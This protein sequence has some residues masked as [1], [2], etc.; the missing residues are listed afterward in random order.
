MLDAWVRFAPRFS[1]LL[2][3]ICQA[4][5]SGDEGRHTPADLQL[6]AGEARAGTPSRQCA[7]LDACGSGVPAADEG[8]DGDARRGRRAAARMPARI[9]ELIAIA[10]EKTWGREVGYCATAAGT[11]INPEIIARGAALSCPHY[12]GRYR[13]FERPEAL[14]AQPR[15]PYCVPRAGSTTW[16]PYIP[17]RPRLSGRRRL[18]RHRRERREDLSQLRRGA[19][20]WSSALVPR[21]VRQCPAPRQGWRWHRL[22]AVPALLTLIPAARRQ[23]Q[24]ISLAVHSRR[25]F[26]ST[27]ERMPLAAL[28]RGQKRLLIG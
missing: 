5:P 11:D 1:R 27:S 2:L 21:P 16:S 7:G 9:S 6:P 20:G 4:L 14:S 19:R 15:S 24:I 28:Q 23:C 25:R 22:R 26:L 18:G 10:G 3:P 8:Q 13:A 12:D 17:R